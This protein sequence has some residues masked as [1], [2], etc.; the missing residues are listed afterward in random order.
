MVLPSRRRRIPWLRVTLFCVY[1]AAIIAF[2]LYERAAH[3]ILS[4]AGDL[5]QQRK[6]GAASVAYKLVV[7]RY[8]LSL[9]VPQA[10][11][12]LAAIEP[13]AVQRAIPGRLRQTLL[14]GLLGSRMDPYV[15]DQLPIVGWTSCA[16][17]LLLVFLTRVSRRAGWAVLALFVGAASAFGGALLLGISGFIPIAWAAEIVNALQPAL[18][19]PTAIYLATWTVIGVTMMLTLS[20]T[21]RRARRPIAESAPSQRPPAKSD[22]PAGATK[23]SIAGRLKKLDEL[24]SRE[25]ITEAEY[26]RERERLLTSI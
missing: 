11:A 4:K 17:V 8:P 19:E 24:R 5:Q 2:G 7:E 10:R 21:S 16:G 14:E 1:V 20:P 18:I 3:Q 6:Y 23:D 12:G 15:V 9:A 22:V 13:A 25:V 26:Q